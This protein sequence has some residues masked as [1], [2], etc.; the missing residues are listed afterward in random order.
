LRVLAEGLQ[1]L[2]DDYL[3][4]QGSRGAGKIAI[5]NIRVTWRGGTSYIEKPQELGH[6]KTL[7]EFIDNL[8]TII[9]TLSSSLSG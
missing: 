9:E 6:Y 3:G 5:K 4:G 8:Q 7:E 1:L 2:V